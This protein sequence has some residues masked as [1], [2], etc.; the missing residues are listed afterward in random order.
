MEIGNDP[1]M[2]VIKFS[3]SGGGVRIRDDLATLQN[4]ETFRFN[5]MI[6]RVGVSLLNIEMKEIAYL[7]MMGI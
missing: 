1:S 4:I 7:S 2:Q 6:E 5:L 3:Y